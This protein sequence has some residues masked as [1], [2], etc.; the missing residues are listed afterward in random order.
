[1]QASTVRR[2]AFVPARWPAATGSR[3]FFAQRPLPSMMIATERAMSGS[4]FS[5]AGF[6][7]RS[8]RSLVRSFTDLDLHDLFFFALEEVVDALAR[9][10][11]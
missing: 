3:R 9:A 1:M 10:R 11:R 4:S 6:S 5:R 2:S 7:A 8:V